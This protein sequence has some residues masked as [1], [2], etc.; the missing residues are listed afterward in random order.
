MTFLHFLQF[1]KSQFRA[2]GLCW[3]PGYAPLLDCCSPYFFALMQCTWLDLT[4]QLQQWWAW[5]KYA[6]R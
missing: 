4:H 1:I 3:L 2:A 5:Q 6:Q